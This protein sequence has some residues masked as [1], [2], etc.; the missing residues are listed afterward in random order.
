MRKCSDNFKLGIKWINKTFLGDLDYA[1]DLA[2]LSS[3]NSDAKEKTE[4]L[5]HFAEQIEIQ[6]NTRKTKRMDFTN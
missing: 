5:H 6:I 1:D 4:R 3:T 2:F